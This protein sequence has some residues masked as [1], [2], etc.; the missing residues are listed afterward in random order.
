MLTPVAHVT[1]PS[2]VRSS[3]PVMTQVPSVSSALSELSP[4]ATHHDVL[5][6][7]ATLIDKCCTDGFKHDEIYPTLQ[8]FDS[9][10]RKD[11]DSNKLFLDVL[12]TMGDR[13]TLNQ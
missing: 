5:N 13:N 9:L 6:R 4:C 12:T 1:P 2:P 10:M 8:E 7:L 3:Q 11:P